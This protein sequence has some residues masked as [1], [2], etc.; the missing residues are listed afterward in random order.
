[1]SWSVREYVKELRRRGA[2][3]NGR[4][5]GVE[6]DLRRLFP[7]GEMEVIVEPCMIVDSEGIILLWYLPGLMNSRRQ[8]RI[9]LSD[10]L[11]HLSLPLNLASIMEVLGNYGKGFQN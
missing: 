1:M 5:P 8:V 6:D 4:Q 3:C 7:A 2:R 10:S 9:D 11:E